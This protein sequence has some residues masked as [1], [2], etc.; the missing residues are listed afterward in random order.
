M[1][2]DDDGAEVEARP[3]AARGKILL[4][5]DDGTSLACAALSPK[6]AEALMAELQAAL[7]TLRRK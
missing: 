2:K 1:V 3:S 4:D 5:L 7:D 6:Q